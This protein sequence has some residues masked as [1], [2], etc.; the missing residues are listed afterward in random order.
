MQVVVFGL[1][2]KGVGKVVGVMGCEGGG[3]VA[4]GDGEAGFE[5]GMEAGAWANVRGLFA[6]L[7]SWV[8][9]GASVEAML[10]DL[11]TRAVSSASEMDLGIEFTGVVCLTSD[12]R[13]GRLKILRGR[14]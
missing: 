1:G 6:K 13:E 8:G 10:K 7:G 3:E 9:E 4:E 2:G 11:G 12:R 14:G 5:G